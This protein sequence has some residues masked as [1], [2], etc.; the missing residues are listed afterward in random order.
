MILPSEVTEQRLSDKQ[1]TLAEK[2]EA[3]REG[4]TV[5]PPAAP[6]ANATA[7]RLQKRKDE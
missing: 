1:V 7:T 6:N 5:P 3:E 2:S 4:R